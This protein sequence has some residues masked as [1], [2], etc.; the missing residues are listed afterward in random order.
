MLF[1]IIDFDHF[2]ISFGAFWRSC[3]N[4]EIQDGR[5]KIAAVWEHNVI[6]VKWRPHTKIFAISGLCSQPFSCY[7]LSCMI[8]LFNKQYISVMCVC[9]SNQ[10][11]I[12]HWEKLNN[13]NNKTLFTWKKY[14]KYRLLANR[15]LIEASSIFGDLSLTLQS[16][17]LI[18]KWGSLLQVRMV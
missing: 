11:N 5:F 3:N 13:N 15:K 16:T 10:E 4:Q 6:C 2:L 18:H 8:K 17:I 7:K 12:W 9:H 14:Y 1:L